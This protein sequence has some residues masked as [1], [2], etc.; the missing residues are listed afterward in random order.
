MSFRKKR[1][2]SDLP[3]WQL[4]GGCPP[5]RRAWTFGL[6]VMSPSTHQLPT[7]LIAWTAIQPA[8]LCR[9]PI[10]GPDRASG[11]SLTGSTRS[12]SSIHEYHLKSVEPPGSFGADIVL[13][14]GQPLGLG[15][16]FGGPTWA[17]D[18]RSLCPPA[19]APAGQTIDAEGKLGY[20]MTLTTREQ[21]PSRQSHFE[22]LYK[23]A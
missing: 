9:V 3:S 2:R 6:L 11:S 19:W 5:T 4:S 22:H 17:S 13:G 12:V 18:A 15:L 7:S 14:E 16:N 1:Q 23:L 8:S 21:H 20:V 10:S